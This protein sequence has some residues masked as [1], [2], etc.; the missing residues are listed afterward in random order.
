MRVVL[1][2]ARGGDETVVLSAGEVAGG[3]GVGAEELVVGIAGLPVHG[4][5]WCIG[6]EKFA[7]VGVT[8]N[9]VD[10]VWGHELA[11]GVGKPQ[12]GVK[13]WPRFALKTAVEHDG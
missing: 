11:Q 4:G 1:A 7:K 12:F 6:R 2:G 13:V 5:R 8:E 9:G 10:G 3:V